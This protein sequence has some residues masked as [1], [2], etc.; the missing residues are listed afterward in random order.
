MSWGLYRKN[1]QERTKLLR[2][3][4]QLSSNRLRSSNNTNLRSSKLE[5]KL[6]PMPMRRSLKTTTNSK[7][8][9]W[10]FKPLSFKSTSLQKN[11]SL[12]KR[13][14]PHSKENRNLSILKFNRRRMSSFRLRKPYLKLKTNWPKKWSWLRRCSKANS[15]RRS[16]RSWFKICRANWKARKSARKR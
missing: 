10:R 12:S 16:T 6:N 8:R 1:Y 7:K 4:G 11:P 9:F 3:W 15:K 2:T 5:R 13:K 14:L